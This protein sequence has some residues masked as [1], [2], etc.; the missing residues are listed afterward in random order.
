MVYEYNL[1]RTELDAKGL[2]VLKQHVSDGKSI[3]EYIDRSTNHSTREVVV[4]VHVHLTH[5]VKSLEIEGNEEHPEL[6]KD[7]LLLDSKPI[8][9]YLVQFTNQPAYS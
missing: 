8:D 7:G 3:P 2:V 6:P 5:I 1:A 4:D 9:S